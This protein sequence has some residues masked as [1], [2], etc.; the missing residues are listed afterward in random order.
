[1]GNLFETIAMD[2]TWGDGQRRFAR[3]FFVGSRRFARHFDAA[4][5]SRDAAM[6]QTTEIL[7]WYGSVCVVLSRAVSCGVVSVAR[8][9]AVGPAK[10]SG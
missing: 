5:I 8:R 3:R 9:A 1:M 4:G 10:R 7:P 6:D 2:R